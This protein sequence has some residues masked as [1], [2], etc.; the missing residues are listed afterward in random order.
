M[1]PNSDAIVRSYESLRPH[2]P[3]TPARG[4]EGCR[5]RGNLHVRHIQHAL[6]SPPPRQL[7]A[8]IIN[9]AC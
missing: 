7:G 5:T 2:A 8:V 4:Y 9:V 6:R 1:A 3:R